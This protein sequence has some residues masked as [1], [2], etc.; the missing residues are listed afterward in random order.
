MFLWAPR[1]L[2]KPHEVGVQKS[3]ILLEFFKSNSKIEKLPK[4]GN[5][6]DVELVWYF[7]RCV[8]KSSLFHQ[9]VLEESDYIQNLNFRPIS[10]K[11]IDLQTY[12]KKLLFGGGKF[13][14]IIPA[15]TENERD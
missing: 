14:L 4:K 12:D 13:Y 11:I 1:S 5:L 8:S 3:L 7:G 6:L 10:F 2:L 15:K 9:K